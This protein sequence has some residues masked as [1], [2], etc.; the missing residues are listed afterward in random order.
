MRSASAEIQTR[1]LLTIAPRKAEMPS[2][3]SLIL[4]PARSGKTF[5]LVQQY[6]TALKSAPAAQS[7]SR[8][9]WISPTARAAADVRG[10]LLTDGLNVCLAPGVTT[11]EE[12]S[13][14]ILANNQPRLRTLTAASQRDLFRRVTGRALEHGQLTHYAQAAIRSGFTDLLADHVRELKRCGIRPGQF[15]KSIKSHPNSLA[16][17]ELAQLYTDYEHLLISHQLCDAEGRHWAAC[18]ELA[19]EAS[20]QFQNIELLV[21]DGFADFTVTQHN[22]LREL[23]RRAKQFLISLPFESTSPTPSSDQPSR[24]DLFAKAR[25]TR[26]ELKRYY[27]QLEEK[28]LQA[29]PTSWPALDHIAQNLFRNPRQM[30][31]ASPAVRDS[32][33]RLEIVGAASAQDEI[34]Q[35]ARRIKTRLT[36][37]EARPGDIALVFRSLG[38]AAPRIRE[39]FTEFGIPFSLEVSERIISSAVVRTLLTLLRLHEEDWRFRRVVA[40]VTNNMLTALDDS[41]QSGERL[42]RELQI[43]GGRDAL[44]EQLDRIAT[45]P[46]ENLHEEDVGRRTAAAAALASFRSLAAA[47]DQLPKSATPLAWSAA[48]AR[49]GTNLGLTIFASVGSAEEEAQASVDQIAWQLLTKHFTSLERLNRW[50]GQPPQT[51]SLGDLLAAL[52][53]LAQHE[54]L[55]RPFDEIGRVRI[56]SAATAR[57]VS[58]RHMYLAGM[59]EQ[60]FPAAERAGRPCSDA[61]YRR[62]AR[63]TEKE[64]P[65]PATGSV[66]PAHAP[67]RAQEEMLLFYEVLTMAEETLTISYPALDDK[68]QQL[69]PSP[70]VTEIR[71]TLNDPNAISTVPPQLSSIPQE[72]VSP[73]SATEWRIQAVARALGSTSVNRD[74]RLLAGIF[75]NPQTKPLGHAIDSGM[76]IVH[77]RA[78]RQDFGPAE[79]IITSA[80]V[81]K[82]LANRY[83]PKHDWSPSQWE[84]YATCPYKFFMQYVL[85]LEPLGDLTLETDYLRRGS[86]MHDVMA[87]SHREWFAATE[88]E[89]PNPSCDEA[90]FQSHV[91]RIL[92]QLVEAMPR[93]GVEAALQELDRRQ[94]GKWITAFQN[95]RKNYAKLWS[96]LNLTSTP[97][98][99]EFRFGPAH[100][101]A[102]NDDDPNS[103]DAPFMLNIGNEEIRVTGRIDRIDVA[104]EAP[105]LV[106]T[107]VDYKSGSRPRMTSEKIESGERLQ[108]ALYVMAAQ[109]M[110]FGE[111]KARP[112][113]AGYWSMQSGV[114][115]TKSYPLRCSDGATISDAWNELRPKIVARVGQFV[116]DIRAGVFPVFS[117]DDHCT[118]HCDFNTVCRIAQVRSLGKALTSD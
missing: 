17:R 83:G 24:D 109:A 38:E 98:Y 39:V 55:P 48:L 15:A 90:A 117:R 60:A 104:G 16:L 4:G 73:L 111:D 82:Q 9:L 58:A 18:D 77:A 36:K 26:V 37:S 80:A 86:L 40:V 22:I 25:A 96:E 31:P 118:S 28:T 93:S 72:D 79:G 21:V 89:P 75:N 51:W 3:V 67:S 42:V 115:T 84:L 113:W 57:T 87:R 94:I 85:R 50:L 49:L 11:F 70:Y 91:E 106:F 47:L 23:S 53:D 59:S 107:V 76:R 112:L 33:P 63:S 95:Q 99:L 2:Q 66:L 10:Q 105:N 45:R 100:K 108:P 103:V 14:Q 19:A 62:F 6:R 44:L 116:K 32:L 71:R 29:R 64:F 1:P 78:D 92:E 54:P 97:A 27:P 20:P 65:L 35:L 74:V 56:L 101:G 88:T 46:D 110:L 41:R 7:R 12:L 102:K 52:V 81:Q 13:D 30:A 34:V 61:D 8:F 43:A 69:P 68:A 5:A 114:T